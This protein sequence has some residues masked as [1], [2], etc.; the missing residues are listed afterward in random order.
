MVA[1][2]QGYLGMDLERWKPASEPA[3]IPA[4]SMVGPYEIVEQIGAGAMGEVY[5][6]KDERLGRLVALKLL[7]RQYTHDARR[8]ARFRQEAKAA[9]ALSHPN[10]LTI[11]EIGE[12]AGA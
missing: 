8:V 2:S 4:G 11:F 9:S 6:A 5:R 7:P 1:T 3:A 12:S 10:I